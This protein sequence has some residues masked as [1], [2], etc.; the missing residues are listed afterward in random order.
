M[1]YENS[2]QKSIVISTSYKKIW[3]RNFIIFRPAS[4]M[5][6]SFAW[7]KLSLLTSACKHVSCVSTSFSL[8]CT[9]EW[10]TGTEDQYQQS[11]WQVTRRSD[12]G[13]D[14]NRKSDN[15]WNTPDSLY[16]SPPYK[17]HNMD[18]HAA[19]SIKWTFRGVRCNVLCFP[20]HTTR[21]IKDGHF[22]SYCRLVN[23]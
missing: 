23:K 7:F 14:W 3:W 12:E 19:C 2:G 5:S 9:A 18:M 6:V 1:K 17:F 11:S 15:R 22:Y 10:N 21:F 20:R 13:I 16:E 8:C 4:N